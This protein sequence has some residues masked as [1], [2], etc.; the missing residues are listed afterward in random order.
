MFH[1]STY[2]LNADVACRLT[3]MDHSKMILLLKARDVNGT[4]LHAT[5][6]AEWYVTQLPLSLQTCPV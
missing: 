1:R 6:V 3:T 2:L 5:L 4:T